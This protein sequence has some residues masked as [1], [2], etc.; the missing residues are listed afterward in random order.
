MKKVIL[1]L[2]CLTL[3]L[4]SFTG[5]NRVKNGSD[6][7]SNTP[8]LSN[9]YIHYADFEKMLEMTTDVV[10]ATLLDYEK[11]ENDDFVCRF[12]I[13]NRY[14]G[15]DTGEII[16]VHQADYEQSMFNLSHESIPGDGEIPSYTVGKDYLLILAR[17]VNVYFIHDQYLNV[18]GNLLLPLDNLAQSKLYNEP[19]EKHA[20]LKDYSTESAIV[21]Y[22]IDILQKNKTPEVWT[23]GK[24]YIQSDDPED[25]V[26]GAPY[27][28]RVK[29]NEFKEL[30]AKDRVET[31]CTV[32]TAFKAPLDCG[33][34]VKIIVFK[35]SVKIGEEYIIAADLHSETQ[36]FE[37]ALAAKKGVLEVSCQEEVL[38]YLADDAN[39]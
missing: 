22:V 28:L 20:A 1:I 30:P 32:V 13:L 19:F 16:H 36:P 8:P 14:W 11:N 4:I 5:C 6:A 34:T 18:G 21:S 38:Q 12:L 37:L 25:I 9:G 23:H 7:P 27:V 33:E 17:H 10:T 39:G 35:D 15:E 26:K 3:L 24:S 2:M 29:V 31:V